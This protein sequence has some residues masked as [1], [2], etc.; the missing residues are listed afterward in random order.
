MATV[1]LARD[2]RHRRGVAVKVLH[3]ELS[4][5]LGPERFL[6]EIEVTASLQHPH[7]L[8]LFDS[9]SA[10]GLLYYVMPYVE[11]ETL[12]ARLEREK[13]LPV[14][15]AVT[16]AR[17]V[18]SALAYAH[19]RG[20]IHRDVK[21]ENVLLA[22]GP[23]EP[24]HALVADFGIALAVQQ[25]GGARMTQTGLS[26]GTPQYMAPE[27]AMGEKTVDARA[28]QHALAAVLYEMLA[29]EPP[30]SGPTSQAVVARVMTESPRSLR[31]QRP[32][33]PAHIDAAVLRALEKL[34]AD[35]FPNVSAFSATLGAPTSAVPTSVDVDASLPSHTT[36]SGASGA[37]AAGWPSFRLT[38]GGAAILAAGALAA[39]AALGWGLRQPASTHPLELEPVRFA[40]EL[41]SATTLG[42]T[43]PAISPD[44]R[45]IVYTGVGPKGTVLYARRVDSLANRPLAGTDDGE[46]PFFSPDGEW[47][48]FYSNGAI[49][50]ARLEL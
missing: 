1:Y 15:D 49:R 48:A 35:R 3:P 6:K 16:L 38:P 34:P 45:T 12:R 27:Q 46:W 25:A 30:F 28:D 22:G 20:V 10:E 41:D 4:A 26:L 19:V 33:V 14:D 13:Q 40:V 50:K 11:G 5:L 24:A 8:P 7:I 42:Q 36:E 23:G 37:R 17:D 21:P 2:L 47:I 43:T 9:G 31:P 32:S 44:T 29:G 39:G 18:A